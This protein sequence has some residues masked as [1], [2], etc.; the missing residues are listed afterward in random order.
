[1]LEARRILVRGVNWLGDAVMTLPALARL[2]EACP[3]ARLAILTH[4]KL[5]DLWRGQ[6][7]IDQVIAFSKGDSPLKT[8][9]AL[10]AEKFEAALILPNSARSAM[11]VWLAGIPERVGY[12]GKWRRAFLTMALPERRGSVPMRKRS[13]P[14][15]Q[16]L[17]QDGGPSP[18]P[19]PPEAH[20]TRHYL[21]LVAGV[22]GNPEPLPPR[23][24]VSDA[25][26]TKV[27]REFR[28]PEGRLLLGLNPG[29]EYGPAKRWESGNFLAA[30]REIQART[31]CSWLIFGGKSDEPL[32]SGLVSGLLAANGGRPDSVFNL[33]GRTTLPQLCALFKACRVVLTNDTGPMHVAAAVGTPVVV[34]FGSTSPE[35][36][37]PGL[38]VRSSHGLIKAGVPCS[39]CFLRE[40]PVDFRCMKSIPVP[41]VVEAVLERL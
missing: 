20:H 3:K 28:I 32:A 36:T 21:E 38:P 26:M 11:E 24:F 12:S 19:I 30:A 1:M 2:R 27:L 31:D 13:L 25:D 17:L 34:P 10:R 41:R 23:L 22:G 9:R 14:E 15:I 7:G 40:C 6:P 16:R 18:Q 8:A 29:A 4:E 33:A 37:G 39:P 35:L 5:A